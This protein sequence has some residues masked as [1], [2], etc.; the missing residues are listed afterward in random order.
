LRRRCCTA[1]FE[2]QRWQA[3]KPPLRQRSGD[4]RGHGSNGSDGGEGGEGGSDGGDGGSEDGSDCGRDGDSEGGWRL[5]VRV[6]GLVRLQRM[7][8]GWRS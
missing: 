2:A 5:G 6:A 1:A 8:G 7:E 3:A 4:G